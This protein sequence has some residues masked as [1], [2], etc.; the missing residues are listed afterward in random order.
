MQLTHSLNLFIPHPSFAIPSF[1]PSFR[2]GTGRVRPKRHSPEP[3][4]AH[5]CSAL[6]AVCGLLSNRSGITSDAYQGNA[7]AWEVTW[8]IT[9][10][11]RSDDFDRGGGRR[12]GA[13]PGAPWR[14][15]YA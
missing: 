15:T 10:V 8:K 13:F 2:G 5:V 14:P 3:G 4:C 6:D 1:L 7:R 11:F 12:P 9:D